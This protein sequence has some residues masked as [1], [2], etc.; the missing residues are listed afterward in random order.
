MQRKAEP[1][2]PS[3]VFFGRDDG[4]HLVAAGE[5]GERD[6]G[7]VA[8]DVAAD[9][10]DDED[11]DA[12]AAVGR[13]Q[14]G[15]DG[16]AE[17]RQVRGGEHAG[18]DVLHVAVGA[19][20]TCGRRGSPRTVSAND[21]GYR[22]ARR[23]VG[24]GQHRR[25]AERDRDQ[26]DVDVLGL[27]RGAQLVQADR[28]GDAHVDEERRLHRE[29]GEQRETAEEHADADRGGQV[30]ARPDA[31]GRGRSCVFWQHG[32]WRHGAFRGWTVGSGA[33]RGGVCGAHETLAVIYESSQISSSSD[34][35]CL[36]SSSIFA[37]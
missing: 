32:L 1:A 5:R 4:G 12:L 9:R 26:R 28:E 19:A 30:A 23:P 33:V 14:H 13:R 18:G 2:R 22:A 29:Q 25:A 34:S 15:R 24:G 17:Q 37:M 6:A 21:G 11:Q 3:Q 36:S 20:G 10:E 8:A 31:L 35:L 7:E 16:G 27:E